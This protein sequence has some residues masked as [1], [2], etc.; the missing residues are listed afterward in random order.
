MGL[1]S[2]YLTELKGFLLVRPRFHRDQGIHR[3]WI[4]GVPKGAGSEIPDEVIRV[5]QGLDER[6]DRSFVT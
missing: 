1:N 2:L 3:P 6:L 5:V 4:P